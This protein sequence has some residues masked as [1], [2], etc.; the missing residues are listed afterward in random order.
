MKKIPEKAGV[1]ILYQGAPLTSHTDG[2]Y[3]TV[4][5]KILISIASEKVFTLLKKENQISTVFT[6]RGSGFIEGF[7]KDNKPILKETLEE[8]GSSVILQDKD[9]DRCIINS[10]GLIILIWR[11]RQTKIKVRKRIY[12]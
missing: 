10:S 9:V 8:K 2:L 4:T 5:E 12:E 1:K 11:I 7:N 6:L 3:S